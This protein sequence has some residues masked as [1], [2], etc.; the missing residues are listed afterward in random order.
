MVRN[1]ADRRQFRGLARPQPD[2][3]AQHQFAQAE[4]L[5][6]KVV[7]ANLET[8]YPVTFPGL[9]GQDDHGWLPGHRAGTDS[10]TNLEAGAI[11]QA[12][13]QQDQIRA[14][15]GKTRRASSPVPTTC[16]LYPAASRM[17]DSEPLRLGSSCT[18]RMRTGAWDE[19]PS[20]RRPYSGYHGD[21]VTALQR[22]CECNVEPSSVIGLM[23]AAS[24]KSNT[25]L[26]CNLDCVGLESGAATRIAQHKPQVDRHCR[27]W[28]LPG[29]ASRGCDFGACYT[30]AVVFKRPRRGEPRHVQAFRLIHQRVTAR[31][32]DRE[33]LSRARGERSFE[34]NR[35]AGGN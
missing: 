25:R 12:N 17:Y 34:A 6:H 31:I 2:L 21:R 18:T 20:M 15:I 22:D 26:L 11:G 24:R 23:R 14:Q 32:K 1:F 33:G 7:R 27:V 30:R 9:G 4:R 35:F 13:V 5:G 16:T 29:I 8:C 10:T 28:S 19:I 3:D